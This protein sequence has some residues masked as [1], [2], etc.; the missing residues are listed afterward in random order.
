MPFSSCIWEIGGKLDWVVLLDCLS[1]NGLSHMIAELFSVANSF[2][3]LGVMQLLPPVSCLWAKL[4]LHALFHSQK[5][6]S[7]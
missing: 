3:L 2:L 6:S 7:K 1:H 4:G 5:L